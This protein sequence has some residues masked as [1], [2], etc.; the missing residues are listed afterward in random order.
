MF[1]LRI[2]VAWRFVLSARYRAEVIDP[3]PG[4]AGD[5]F[6]SISTDD[7]AAA[8]IAAL[9]APAG[10]YN[11]VDDE[12]LTRAGYDRALAEAAGVRRVRRLAIRAKSTE[13][14][15]RSHRV[16]NSK[17]RATTGWAP[18]YPSSPTGSRIWWH[19]PAAEACRRPGPP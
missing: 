19:R 3:L 9:G 13:H 17:F 16:S 15:A 8:V 4:K 10:I 5:Y 14:V 2:F 18:R 12:P 7:A 1:F 11:I 6:S